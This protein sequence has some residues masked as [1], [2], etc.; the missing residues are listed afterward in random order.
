MN[1]SF[2]LVKKEE[3]QKQKY[4][5]NVKCG[6]LC[7][8][9]YNNEKALEYYENCNKIIEKDSFQFCYVKILEGI[10]YEKLHKISL[11]LEKYK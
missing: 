2:T 9:L 6:I 4:Y 8:L 7:S 5:N 11:S 10:V 3:I 1:E